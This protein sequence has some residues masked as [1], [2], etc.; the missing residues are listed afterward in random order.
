MTKIVLDACRLPYKHIDRE[1][2]PVLTPPYRTSAQHPFH[3]G[4]VAQTRDTSQAHAPYTVSASAG[5]LCPFR[6]TSSF[7]VRTVLP[8]PTTHSH[9]IG[10]TLW[11]APN[12]SSERGLR[13]ERAAGCARAHRRLSSNR[14]THPCVVS[15]RRARR[16]RW[17][18]R[19]RRRALVM[20]P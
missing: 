13:S 7:H 1:C 12:T 10:A 8:V 16:A 3:T 18:R 14:M 5:H 2:C 17:A 19:V 4:T 6:D 11:S 9:G 20:G 15:R